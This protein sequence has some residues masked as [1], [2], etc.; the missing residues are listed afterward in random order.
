[1]RGAPANLIAIQMYRDQA[2]SRRS[3]AQR[4]PTPVDAASVAV[5]R[6]GL[7]LLIA[8][9]AIGYLASDWIAYSFLDPEFHFTF[10]GFDWV[11]PWPGVG[12]YLH[13]AALAVL[14]LCVAAGVAHRI[15]AP[16]L[17]VGFA[18]VFL[19]DKTEYLNHFYA[20]ILLLALIAVAP[21]DRA[22][23]V[24]AWRNPDR[25]RTVP[26]WAVWMLRF[27]VGVIY[28]YAGVAKLGTDWLA[29]EPMGSWLAQRSDLPLLGPL[30]GAPWAG[31]V[32]SWGGLA[33]DL[34]IVPLL[35]W[36]RTRAA[37]FCL[38]VAFHL[39]NAV[40]FEIGI[41]PPMMI[42][43]TTVFFDPDWPRRAW[44]W[45][46]GR[47]R[48]AIPAMEPGRSTAAPGE[49]SAPSRWTAR[50]LVPVLVTWAAVQL[51]VPL[52]HHLYEGPVHWTEEG[53]RFAWH[54]KLRQKHGWA[55]FT[56]V[57]RRTGE[58]R[59]LGTANLITARQ[60]AAASTRPDMILQLAHRLAER[61]RARGHDVE[62]S[63]QVLVSLNDRPARHLV[64]PARDLS[65][66]PRNLRRGDWIGPEPPLG[67]Q[68][69]T[70][71]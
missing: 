18:Y 47:G 40:I 45:L 27:Q 46:A 71:R 1:M 70:G 49:H 54:M 2:D 41:F 17:A 37:A 42:A 26:V 6:I 12:L 39:A 19:L 53:H 15:A 58:R 60:H 63:A 64:D 61:E 32:F 7:G 8:V 25:P 24:A 52:R 38:A 20:A 35:L 21:A 10:Q 4:L 67:R 69:P 13:F 65:A 11:R 59:V 14:G 62:I 66:V 43:A 55:T 68:P 5:L 23:S 51:L 9:E 3:L 50:V 28:V 30:L 33:F 31:V 34:A 56:A 29:G 44:G 36:R 16:L 57:D 22:M 48:G